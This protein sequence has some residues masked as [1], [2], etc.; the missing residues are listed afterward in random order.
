M[1]T[2]H[3][4][5]ANIKKQL[6]AVHDTKV[7]TILDG[8]SVDGLVEHLE[9]HTLNFACLY[10]GELEP[11]LAEVAPYL[12][13]L[14]PGSEFT[15]W[16]ISQGWGKHWGIFAVSEQSLSVV[17][18]H[19]RRFLRVKSPEG[20][21]LY[22]R[23]YDPRVLRT[24]LPTCNDTETRFIFGPTTFLAC[25]D[26]E[27]TTLIVFTPD[28]GAPNQRKIDLLSTRE[29]TVTDFLPDSSSRIDD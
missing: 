13:E 3:K 19:F 29:Q 24:Y 11:D 21:V 7:Y 17:R 26:Q 9:E 10:R 8:A 2:D 1:S 15:N 28:E 22:F 27:P 4:I 5:I 16:V 25:E 6:F 18:R 14:T 20:K 12:V 23:Y